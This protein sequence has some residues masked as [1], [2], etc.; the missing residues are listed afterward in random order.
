MA[1]ILRRGSSLFSYKSAFTIPL[2]FERNSKRFTS[3]LSFHKD[4]PEN[5]ESTPFDFSSENLSKIKQIISK[6][7]KNYE[8][9]AMIP[10]LDIAQRQCGGWL[11]L[12][13]MNKVAKVLTVPPMQVYEV[14]SFY[15]MFNR[16][17]VGKYHVQVCTTTPCMLRDA[18]TILDVCKKNLGVDVGGTTKDGLF[19]LGE[20]ECA[21]ACVNAPMLSVGD[22]Y[23]EDLTPET[24]NQILDAFKRGEK[25]KPGPQDGKRKTCEGPDG[26]TT[27]L[28]T[29][30]GPGQFFRAYLA[31][32]QFCD[33]NLTIMK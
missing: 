17:P 18:Y 4:T 10:I 32:Q 16:S 15:T 26:K 27:L 12:A 6:Y 1:S 20:V 19:T 5:N 7:P 25:P 3:A 23:Y 13:A 8:R 24:T 2:I 28:E 29:P 30:P 22:D 33:S 31:G 11:P 21:G 14:A 9:A